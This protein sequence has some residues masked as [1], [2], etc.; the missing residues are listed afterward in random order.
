MC[1]ALANCISPDCRVSWV[2]A[3]KRSRELALADAT[4][5]PM[6]YCEVRSVCRTDAR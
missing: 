5:A 2:S 1:Q 3:A 4:A 6:R